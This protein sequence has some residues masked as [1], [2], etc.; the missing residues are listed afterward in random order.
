MIAS[1]TVCSF[2]LLLMMRIEK[3][4]RTYRYINNL[5][6]PTENNTK[7]QCLS[8]YFGYLQCVFSF[9]FVVVVGFSGTY[10][11]RITCK[12]SS[13]KQLLYLFFWISKWIHWFFSS[14]LSLYSSRKKTEKRT[15]KKYNTR[16]EQ[17]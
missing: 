8:Q 17:I 11:H 1:G 13:V 12:C 9:Y 4:L 7:N 5:W 10:C 14:L 16:P 6:I 3:T 15:K 2:L